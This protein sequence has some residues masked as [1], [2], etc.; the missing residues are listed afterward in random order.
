MPDDPAPEPE[1]TDP[2]A[3]PDAPAPPW[4]SDDFDPERAWKKLQAVED[5]KRKA[6]E[7]A[8][9]AEAELKKREDEKKTDQ[10]K[11]E[12]ELAEVKKTAGSASQ[13]AIR[14]RVALRK[15]LTETQAKRLVGDTEEEMAE[16]ADE[17]LA[18]FKSDD[19]PE[20]DSRRR[21]TERLRPGAAPSADAEPSSP[22]ELAQ[23]VSRGW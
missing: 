16:D 8:E 1:P 12:E 15:G 9:K 4:K 3:K 22:K 17:L 19:E 2:E 6:R 13:E 11:L 21:P 5:D 18:S 23:Q 14:L 20:Q 10:Q 7:R